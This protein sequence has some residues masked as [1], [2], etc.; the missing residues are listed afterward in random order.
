M[1]DGDVE[2]H[3]NAIA[4]M[5]R[6]LARFHPVR[7]LE[8][9]ESDKEGGMVRFSWQYSEATPLDLQM[10]ADAVNTIKA[11]SI[12]DSRAGASSSGLRPCDKT[13]QP[14]HPSVK[15]IRRSLSSSS[16]RF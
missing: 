15:R 13:K 4:G 8:V 7:W 16:K 10:I 6:V 3:S 11:P 9:Q 5:T 2:G 14:I 1:S 12:G